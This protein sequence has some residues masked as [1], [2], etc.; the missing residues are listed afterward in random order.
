MTI[1]VFGSINIDL[2]VRVPRLP[3]KGETTIGDRFFTASGGKAA[4]QAVAA[5][6]LGM[7]TNLVG[8]VGKDYFGQI[9]LENLQAA[10]VG[11]DNVIVNDSTHS[12]VASIAV[13]RNGENTIACAA[14]ANY[15]VSEEDVNRFVA[16]LPQSKVALLDL[17]ILMP[18][19]LAA[20]REARN[21]ECILILDPAPARTNLPTELYSLVDII[22]PNRLEASQL[23]GFTVDGVTTARQ[24][25]S[26]FHQ[27]GAKTIIITMGERGV[28]CSTPDDSFSI[29]AIRTRAVDTV[30][31]G[32]AFNGALAAAI[33]SGKSLREAVE[34]GTVAGYLAVTKSG[35]QSSL[36]DKETFFAELSKHKF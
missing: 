7:T 16:L 15:F 18:A 8:Q 36:P 4:N 13:A 1:V 14:G 28:F 3:S 11:I 2:V 26:Y 27:M 24:A 19:V 17:G 21:S 22:T 32:D 31:A 20:A 9:L 12:G 29:P 35:A 33:A 10:G 25:T 23:V 30:A 6:K 34:W 5:A